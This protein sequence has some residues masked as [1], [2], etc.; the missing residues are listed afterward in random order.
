LSP[1]CIFDESFD[2]FYEK[3]EPYCEKMSH[4]AMLKSLPTISRSWS[5]CG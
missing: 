4:I 3:Y 1:S 2:Q 5:R